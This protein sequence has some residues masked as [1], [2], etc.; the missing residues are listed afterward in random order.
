MCYTTTNAKWFA[1]M[2]R[3]MQTKHLDTVEADSK[4][5]KL[6]ATLN[7]QQRSR[8]AEAQYTKAQKQK[9]Q[10]IFE[11]VRAAAIRSKCY[12]TYRDK[13]MTVTAYKPKAAD[14]LDLGRVEKQLEQLGCEKAT[15]D[16]SIIYRFI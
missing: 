1:D 16:Q 11:I 8:E 7:A 4:Q 13:F 12:I 2:E 3:R 5:A 14:K 10:E 9:A 15:T 6:F